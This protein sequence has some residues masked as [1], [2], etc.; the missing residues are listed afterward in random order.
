ML[1][2]IPTSTS[3]S[4]F[5]INQAYADYVSEAD[6]VPLL[7]NPHNDALM[8]AV[9]CD[10]LILP[11]GIDID[12]V[13]YNEDN[14]HSISVDPVKDD[15]ERKLLVAFINEGKPIFGICRG[16]Q[17]I[18]REYM[19]HSTKAERKRLSFQQHINHHALAHELD[20]DRSRAAHHVYADRNVLYGEDHSQYRRMFVNSMHHQCLWAD[21]NKKGESRWIIGN[22]RILAQTRYG[23]SAKEAGTI[24][25][26]FDIQN[27]GNSRIL[28]VQ[29]H[30]EEMKD[31]ALL[32]T[33]FTNTQGEHVYAPTPETLEVEAE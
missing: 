16:F 17:L 32:R 29:W 6:F 12:P 1:I 10:G 33:F 18:V 24:I 25:E 8:M 3:K 15:F 26:A 2:C 27:W 28:A 21:P 13:F 19:R 22:L 9:T 23:V 30:P 14:I 11:G 5:Y 4:Q 31:I 20:L 7:A